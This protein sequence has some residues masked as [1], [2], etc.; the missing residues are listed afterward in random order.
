[1]SNRI[2]GLSVAVLIFVGCLLVAPVSWALVKKTGSGLC[3]P[4]H[5]SYYER[6]KNYQPFDTVGA[7][8][9]SGGR[10][11]KGLQATDASSANDGEYDRSEFGHGWLDMDKDGQDARAEALI[12]QSTIPVTFAGTDQERV[13]R[14]RWISPFSGNVIMDASTAD[15]DHVIPLKFAW[16]HGADGWPEDKRHKFANDPRNIWIVEASL[17]RSKEPAELLSGY[18]RPTSVAILPGLFG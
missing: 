17:N 7:C 6:T 18:H 11:P 5:S 1:M 10:L 16:L 9:E 3:H 12:D 14:G 15:A 4:E 13:V 2:P 8:L